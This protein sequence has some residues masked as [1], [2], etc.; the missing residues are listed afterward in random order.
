ME[1]ET[2]KMLPLEKQKVQT[3]EIQ[4]IQSLEKQEIRMKQTSEV[5][6]KILKEIQKTRKD[7]PR[8]IQKSGVLKEMLGEFIGEVQPSDVGS[9]APKEIRN[10][11]SGEI[12][13]EIETSGVSREDVVRMAPRVEAELERCGTFSLASYS[14][15]TS[16]TFS[17]SP[18]TCS[19]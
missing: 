12:L 10:E 19:T 16:C 6:Q 7:F 3:L 4:E 13:R 18:S 8:E 17:I 2:S 14:I 11:I 1:I 5:A 9:E 15:F